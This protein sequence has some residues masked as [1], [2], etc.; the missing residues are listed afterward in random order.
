MADNDLCETPQ[1]TQQSVLNRTG[2]DKF[3]LV[4]NLPQILQEQ[5][6]VNNDLKIDSL[7]M[8]VF[9][10]IVPTI[11]IPS[12]AL[13]FAGQT[14]NV[15]GLVR[16]NYSP[17][18]VNFVVD[19]NFKNYWLLWKWLSYYNNPRTGSYG[20]NFQETKEKNIQR[21]NLKEY[22][23]NLSIL[24]LNEYNQT[25]VEFIYYNAFITS[26]GDISYNYRTPDIIESLAEFQFSQLDVKL[27]SN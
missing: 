2:K 8:S 10:A 13:P 26:L 12:L 25:V 1:P 15:T 23:T 27:F 11:Q 9:G 3:I 20:D 21:G 22:Q 7:Q 6:P 19:N 18:S 14:Y 17:L 4:L 16:P 24:G 5:T